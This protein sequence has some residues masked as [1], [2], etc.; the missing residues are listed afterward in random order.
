MFVSE[1]MCW[2]SN[3][4]ESGYRVNT[5]PRKLIAHL[6]IVVPILSILIGLW[7]RF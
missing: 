5:I 1:I 2:L 6:E 7:D 4:S 3:T